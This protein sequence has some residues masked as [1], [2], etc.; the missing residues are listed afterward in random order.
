MLEVGRSV[1]APGP[2]CA[3]RDSLSADGMAGHGDASVLEDV[4][5]LAPFGVGVAV[6]EGHEGDVP[7]LRGELRAIVDEAALVVVDNLELEPSQLVEL[8]TAFAPRELMTDWSKMPIMPEHD[9][10]EGAPTVNCEGEPLVRW[11]GNVVDRETGKPLTLL[12]DI[13]Y[14]RASSVR[15]RPRAAARPCGRA[16]SRLRLSDS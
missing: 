10:V 2:T 5:R 7:R 15:A 9:G 16:V 12:A 1:H 4:R 14:V 11:L 13:G 3:R 6:R 8:M